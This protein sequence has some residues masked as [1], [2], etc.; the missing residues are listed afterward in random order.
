MVLDEIAR[1]ASPNARRRSSPAPC[2]R[3]ASGRLARCR[4]G[5]AHQRRVEEAIRSLANH[6]VRQVIGVR[7]GPA[8]EVGPRHQVP[9]AIPGERL[10]LTQR[11]R[12]PGAATES[13]MTRIRKRPSPR[14]APSRGRLSPCAGRTITTSR[15]CRSIPRWRRRSM[16]SSR[17]GARRGSPAPRKWCESP[18]TF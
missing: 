6:P 11:Q 17:A 3:R 10:R 9:R 1:V 15:R 13:I 16:S 12:A 8:V 5:E 14:R 7:A 2:W 18:P 4:I